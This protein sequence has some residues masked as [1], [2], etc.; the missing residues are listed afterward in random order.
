MRYGLPNIETLIQKRAKSKLVF[1]E[2]DYV[3]DS[4]NQA[5]RQT[6]AEYTQA[7]AKQYA[8]KPKPRVFVIDDD[9]EYKAF[10]KAHRA[11]EKAEQEN[12]NA[13][14]SSNL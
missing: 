13:V 4:Q 7:Y 8:P 2:G 3:R 14:A 12:A 10:L 11:K 5:N 9:E 1:A 6:Q